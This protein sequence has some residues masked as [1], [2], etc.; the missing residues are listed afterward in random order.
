MIL[1]GKVD[2]PGGPYGQRAGSGTIRDKEA[3]G[4]R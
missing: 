2:D 4:E 3:K 1:A